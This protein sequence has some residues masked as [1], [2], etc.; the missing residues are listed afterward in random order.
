MIS[1]WPYYP[2]N[3]HQAF[4]TRLCFPVCA[5]INGAC[6]MWRKKTL[7]NIILIPKSKQKIKLQRD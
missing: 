2:D 1:S 6:T 4:D 3:V 5:S 7:E